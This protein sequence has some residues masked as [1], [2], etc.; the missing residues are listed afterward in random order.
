MNKTLLIGILL[1]SQI[2]INAQEFIDGPANIRNTP[3]GEIILSID[4]N[5]NIEVWENTEDWYKIVVIG[6]IKESSLKNKILLKDSEIYDNKLKKIGKA[7]TD[8]DISGNFEESE[9]EGYLHVLIVGYTF[10][11]NIKELTID[12]IKLNKQIVFSDSSKTQLLIY[13]DNGTT[14][15]HSIET[16]YLLTSKWI[17][18]EFEELLIKSLK[19]KKFATGSEGCDTK[20]DLIFYPKLSK[21]DTIYYSK[22]ADRFELQNNYLIS[23]KYGCCGAENSFELSTFP[24][25]ETFLEYNTSF[26]HIEIPNTKNELFFG[27][28]VEPR[29]QDTTGTIVCELNYAFNFKKSGRI[30]FK[31]KTESQRENI[32]PFTPDIELISKSSQDKIYKQLDYSEMTAWSLNNCNDFSKISNVGIKITFTNDSNGNTKEYEVYIENGKI[33]Y[34][35]LIIDL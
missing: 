29:F 18:G 14:Y 1:I 26:Y 4:D 27:V 35:E 23:E 8:L 28:N 32:T 12:E 5:V 7:I 30:V 22:K 3:K 17:N 24:G 33:K 2:S 15:Y 31:T 16:N 13:K 19:T 20:I 25:N 34:D 11:T 21:T 6:Y 10:R 9:I